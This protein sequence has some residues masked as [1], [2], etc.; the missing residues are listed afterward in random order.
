[1]TP[2]SIFNV[3]PIGRYWLAVVETREKPPR[4]AGYIALTGSIY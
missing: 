3:G 2:S 1:M 4:D